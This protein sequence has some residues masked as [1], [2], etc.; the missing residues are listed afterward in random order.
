V[1]GF[2]SNKAV[3]CRPRAMSRHRARRRT[4]PRSV[5]RRGWSRARASR[6]VPSPPTS[7]RPLRQPDLSEHRGDVFAAAQLRGEQPVTPRG[8]HLG[9]V[10]VGDRPTVGDHTDPPDREPPGQI[11]Q[12]ALQFVASW[13][14]CCPRM[15]CANRR[16]STVRTRSQ[17]GEGGSRRRRCTNLVRAVPS[18]VCDSTRRLVGATR[19]RPPRRSQTAPSN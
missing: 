10:V 5:C 18:G 16:F 4:P 3:S 15:A 7:R 14:G 11:L 6:T 8:L 9:A 12:H 17:R 13:L 19:A 1:R 2:V